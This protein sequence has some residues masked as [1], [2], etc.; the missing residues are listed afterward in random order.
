M[1][2]YVEYEGSTELG[3]FY[4]RCEYATAI[5]HIDVCLF[6]AIYI[7]LAVE[8]KLYLDQR[9]AQ[10][11]VADARQRL[12]RF[13]DT[14]P[15]HADFAEVDKAQFKELNRRYRN[16]RKKNKKRDDQV[17]KDCYVS[18]GAPPKAGSLVA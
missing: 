2:G 1:D 8:V 5:S 16:D 6:L 9:A 18:I 15:I 10:T 12:L 3:Q 14:I 11:A 13:Y 7:N 17:L 4:I